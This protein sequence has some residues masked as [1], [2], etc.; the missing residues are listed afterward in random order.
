[1]K[2]STAVVIFF[3]NPLPGKTKT[4]LAQKVGDDLALGIYERLVHR[5]RE[6]IANTPYPLYVFFSEK[7]EPVYWPSPPF[8]Y[9]I[10]EGG[11]LGERMHL[12]FEEL[13]D[14]YSKVLLIG[15]DTPVITDILLISAQQ[16]LEEREVVLGP[17][18][19]GGYYLIGLKRTQEHLFLEMPWSTDRVLGLTCSRLEQNG[20]SYGLLPVLRD[21]DTYEDWLFY[22]E[23]FF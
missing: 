9:R 21:V 5:L 20:I 11:D 16:M 8:H 18:E 13:L 10:Q 15:T 22:Q 17:S 4:R 6:G 3:K 23:L 2:G 14:K 19:D 12:A 7:I 1:M